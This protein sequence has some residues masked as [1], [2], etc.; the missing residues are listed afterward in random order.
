MTFPQ[1]TVPLKVRVSIFLLGRQK[2]ASGETE[3]QLQQ[4]PKTQKADAY[5]KVQEHFKQSKSA[6]GIS[7]D[8]V[9]YYDPYF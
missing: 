5:E 4:E 9:S 3:G 2:T 1:T 6:E 8:R 7:L